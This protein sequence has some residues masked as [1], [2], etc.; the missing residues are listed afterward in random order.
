MS[1]SLQ[2]IIEDQ[3]INGLGAQYGYALR[4]RLILKELKLIQPILKKDLPLHISE[5]F[6]YLVDSSKTGTILYLSKL[7]DRPSKGSKTRSITKFINQIQSNKIDIVSNHYF[8]ESQ[9]PKF[10]SRHSNLILKH[11]DLNVSCKKFLD[12]VLIKIKL[13]KGIGQPINKIRIWRDK[14]IAHSEKYD[15]SLK[16]GDEEIETL[17]EL[18]NFLLDY[19][20]SFVNTGN[21]VFTDRANASF[22]RELFKDY[23]NN[24]LGDLLTSN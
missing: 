5:L 13:M 24:S 23:I 10:I 1:N 8:L 9:W 20:N 3:H 22:V 6:V 12:V 19:V 2:E 15:E 7:Y 21:A 4:H 14:F 16:M 11:P 17:L 18:A